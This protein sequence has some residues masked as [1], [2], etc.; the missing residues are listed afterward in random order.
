M[1]KL[2]DQI[3]N[4]KRI[5]GEPLHE[6]WL[7]FQKLLLQSLTHGFPDHF[8]LQYFY[9]SLDSITTGVVDQL[10]QGGLMQQPYEVASLLFDEMTKVNRTWNTR[11]DHV[12]S[13]QLSISK[14]KIEKEHERDDNMAKM[15]TQINLLSKHVIGGGLKSVNVVG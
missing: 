5:E 15:M 8:L 7:R 2:R 13:L 9:Y 14:E 12:S 1:V 10:S 4:F 6:T 3:Q 11:E